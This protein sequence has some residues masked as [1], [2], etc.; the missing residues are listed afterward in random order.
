MT[1]EAV[2][3]PRLKI[4]AGGDAMIAPDVIKSYNTQKNKRKLGNQNNPGIKT[5]KV[6]SFASN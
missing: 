6:I 4:T 2:I 3:L 5:T 1:L